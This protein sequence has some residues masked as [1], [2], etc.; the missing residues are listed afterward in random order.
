MTKSGS[1][2]SEGSNTK[3]ESILG[4]A[5]TGVRNLLVVSFEIVIFILYILTINNCLMVDE[6]L[7]TKSTRASTSS[8]HEVSKI[9]IFFLFKSPIQ[10]ILFLL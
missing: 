10:N 5:V 1:M 6:I 8:S 7:R 2:D 3:R 4:M 9:Y